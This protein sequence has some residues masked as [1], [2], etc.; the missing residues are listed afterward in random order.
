M[1]SISCDVCKKHISGAHK[2]V[3]YITILDKDLCMSCSDKLTEATKRYAAS[4][5]PYGFRDYQA[6]L[7]RTLGKMCGK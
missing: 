7:Q 1:T 6:T 3:N 5:A 2:D 4:H